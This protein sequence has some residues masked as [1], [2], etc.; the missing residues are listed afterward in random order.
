MYEIVPG[1]FSNVCAV[2]IV[3]SIISQDN[4]QIEE[5]YS[6]VMAEIY[7]DADMN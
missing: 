4:Q 1:F 5:E 2:I 3:N 7:D 6:A